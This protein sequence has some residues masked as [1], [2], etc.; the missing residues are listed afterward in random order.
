MVTY[1]PYG[2][3]GEAC[4]GKMQQ[5]S[6]SNPFANPQHP[7]IFTLLSTATFPLGLGSVRKNCCS[8]LPCSK[9]L[10]TN[11]LTKAKDAMEW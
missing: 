10:V 6:Y 2:K 5:S 11:C 9:I 3:A 1:H 8:T 7:A 4:S